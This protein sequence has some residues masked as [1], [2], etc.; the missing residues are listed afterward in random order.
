V[1]T[2]FVCV[3]LRPHALF[4]EVILQGYDIWNGIRKPLNGA[5]TVNTHTRRLNAL[6]AFPRVCRMA[7]LVMHVVT[8]SCVYK[9]VQ[10]KFG[11]KH[12]GTWSAT[13]L[14]PRY[15]RY[16]PAVFF[17]HLFSLCFHSRKEKIRRA[18]LTFFT[19]WN[20]VTWVRKSGSV[21][22]K[23][24]CIHKALILGITVN[25]EPEMTWEGLI[26]NFF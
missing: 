25:N 5:M 15:L 21:C 4:P 8:C 22:N 13:T 3:A 12:A 17:R 20:C 9:I 16:R 14:P 10:L 23:S 7:W 19:A 6:V 11:L 24:N 2:V 1:D 26:D 18:F